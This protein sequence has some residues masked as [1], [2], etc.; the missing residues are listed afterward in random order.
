[1]KTIILL[2][3]LF[4]NSMV[5]KPMEKR[6][7]S[8]G[9]RV[10][11][12]NYKSVKYSDKTLQ[13]LELLVN[14]IDS[15]NIY[16]IGHSMG[17]LIARKYIENGYN[18]KKIKSIITL[19]TPHNTSRVGK[20]ISNS[21]FNKIL[22]SAGDSGILSN[23]NVTWNEKVPLG[24]IAG[25]FPIGLNNI[26]KS[27]HKNEEPSDGTVFLDEAILKNCTDSIIIDSSH[28]GLIYSKNLLK[29]INSIYSLFKINITIDN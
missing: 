7:L 6:F 11:Q 4:M 8:L 13:K 27:F 28:T 17:G 10:Y 16:F 14:S 26:L 25:V 15:E 9:Y 12:F 5:M 24:C 18:I 20:V 3:G 22:G 23:N 19:G 1:M 29:K 2:H 21:I